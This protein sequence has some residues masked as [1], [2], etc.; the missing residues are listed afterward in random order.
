MYGSLVA[1]EY[2]SIRFKQH[3]T[4]NADMIACEATHPVRTNQGHSKDTTCDIGR[5]ILTL[6]TW[7]YLD[8]DLAL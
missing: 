1:K 4:P 3:G 8:V 2:F 6:A 7:L 5:Y